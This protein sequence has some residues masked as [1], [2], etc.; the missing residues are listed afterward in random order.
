MPKPAKKPALRGVITIM[1]AFT[2]LL[3]VGFTLAHAKLQSEL[4][5]LAILTGGM[6][7]IVKA[8]QI[9]TANDEQALIALADAMRDFDWIS[10]IHFSKYNRLRPLAVIKIYDQNDQLIAMEKCFMGDPK[11]LAQLESKADGNKNKYK[12]LSSLGA[13][14]GRKNWG[15]SMFRSTDIFKSEWIEARYTILDI[16]YIPEHGHF[17]YTFAA[18]GYPILVSL[19]KML[20]VYFWTAILLLCAILLVRKKLTAVPASPLEDAQVPGPNPTDEE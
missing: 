13:V 11:R 9:K 2:A 7:V 15:P 17:Y 3:L 5:G 20:P 18:E 12:G 14:D 10:R 19:Q 8:E 16:V 1:S 4:M 6:E